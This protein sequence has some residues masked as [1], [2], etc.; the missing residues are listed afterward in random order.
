MG[1]IKRVQAQVGV[2]LAGFHNIS[3]QNLPCLLTVRPFYSPFIC[4]QSASV[5]P[6]GVS[7]THK[8][9]AS[10]NEMKIIFRSRQF[11][12]HLSFL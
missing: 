8:K 4:V 9:G 6:N 2:D 10:T 5:V 12:P 7:S 11:R 1:Q 3:K